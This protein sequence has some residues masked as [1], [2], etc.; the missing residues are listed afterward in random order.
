MDE[1]SSKTILEMSQKFANK[2][3]KQLLIFGLIEI[4]LEA[5]QTFQKKCQREKHLL[6]NNISPVTSLQIQFSARKAAKMCFSALIE[7]RINL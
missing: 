5:P 2:G 7:P 1:F 4:N 6:I 3:Y